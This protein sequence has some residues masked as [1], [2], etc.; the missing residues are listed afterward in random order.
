MWKA[1][2]WKGPLLWNYSFTLLHWEEKQEYLEK[3]GRLHRDPTPHTLLHLFY[4]KTWCTDG[5]SNREL[6]VSFQC[7][8][9]SQQWAGWVHTNGWGGWGRVCVL[10]ALFTL[11]AAAACSFMSVWPWCWYRGGITT[12]TTTGLVWFNFY[13]NTMQQQP[14]HTQHLTG[15]QTCKYFTITYILYLLLAWQEK[16]GEAVFPDP[17][18]QMKGP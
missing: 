15:L 3:T 5:N 6:K 12:D 16:Q 7:V 17:S 8:W 13:H 4:C 18:V 1:L 2:N 10:T 9:G 11:T 14:P